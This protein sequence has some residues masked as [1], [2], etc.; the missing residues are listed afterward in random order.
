MKFKLWMLGLP[1]LLAAG[2]ASAETLSVKVASANF[3]ARPHESAEL[4]FTADKFFPVDVVEKKNGWVKVRDFEGDEAWVLEKTLGA[5]P[6]VVV[7]T[8][9][10]NIREAANTTS[11][12][13]FQVKR[14]EV[15]K[16]EERKENWI[17]VVDANGDGGWIR[18]DMVWGE[19]LVAQVVDKATEVV[20]SG[21]GAKE[22][23]AT[24]D[25][26]TETVTEKVAE[27]VTKVPPATTAT[28]PPSATELEILSKKATEW[29]SKPE[30]LEALCRAYLEHAAP[31]AKPE[32]VSEK[33]KAVPKPAHAQ[34]KASKPK[35]SEKVSAA[36]KPK[37]SEKPKKAQGK[38]A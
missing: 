16:I 11:D 29:A 15:F 17:K 22:T 31:A 5:T 34:S 4:K 13:L 25:K 1:L 30:N 24:I 21:A 2:S 20:K 33:P 10:A 38:K 36:S 3:R 23:S 26:V 18:E 28:K 37:G 19:P 32:K 7:S 12:V 35:S 14:G 6:S 9:K 8:D 27:V